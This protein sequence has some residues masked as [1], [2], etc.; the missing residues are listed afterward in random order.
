MQQYEIS[1]INHGD[2]INNSNICFITFV[3]LMC[4]C[5]YYKHQYTYYKHQYTYMFRIL[6]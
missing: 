4:V 2:N 6:L 1:T 5:T 3:I